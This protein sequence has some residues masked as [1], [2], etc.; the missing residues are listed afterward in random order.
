MPLLAG[1]RGGE[2][3]IQGWSVIGWFVEGGWR[4]AGL[5]E[6]LADLG[7]GSRRDRPGRSWRKWENLIDTIIWVAM[8]VN[9]EVRSVR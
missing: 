7:E 8:S 6:G 2:E 5:E 9:G 1:F 4:A 3:R